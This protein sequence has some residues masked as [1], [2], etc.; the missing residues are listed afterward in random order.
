MRQELF[1][2][3]VEELKSREHLSPRRIGLER[4]A[5]ENQ[6]DQLLVFAQVLDHNLEELACSIKV[7]P[8]LIRGVC[9][10]E[11]VPDEDTN[12]WQQHARLRARLG[13]A[14]HPIQEAV[15]DILAATVRASSTIENLN[16]RLR[17]YFFL[18]RH[19]N[20]LYLDLLH[21][22]LNHRRF[23]R[24]ERPERAGKS[25]VEILTG[26]TYPHWL[27]ELGFKRFRRAS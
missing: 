20:Q 11:G 12:K 1:D 9:E 18:R 26:R 3:V 6:R 15:K 2:F 7:P 19:L 14:F 22:F 27:E 23:L 13:N 5:L 25:P 17:N 16:S 4:R 8:A 21:F 10:L 24:S